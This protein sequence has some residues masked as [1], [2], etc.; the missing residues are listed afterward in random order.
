MDAR[1]LAKALAEP[2]YVKTL[3]PNGWTALIAMARAERL[4]GSLA[5]RLDGL[6]LPA[7]VARILAS[8]RAN[9]DT[10]RTQ[11]LWEAE[12]A[13]RALAPL[14]LEPI[15]LKGTAFAAAGLDAGNGR[16]IGDLDILIAR[17]RLEEA[18]A[19]LLAAGWEWVKPDP[20]DDL[21]YRTHMHE[22]PPMIHASRDRMIDVH[23]TILPLTARPRPDAARLIADS[24]ALG[25]G[26]RILCCEDMIIHAVAHLF[27][28]GD[29][30]GGLRN[31]WDIDRLIRECGDGPDFWGRLIE[32]ARLHQLAKSTSRA[33][34]LTH[35]LFDTP[36]DPHFAWEGR[37]GDVFY[38]GRLLARDRWGRPSRKLLRLAFY[39]RSHWIRMP[40]LMLARHLWAKW[41]K[42]V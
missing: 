27:A 37:K 5:W 9:A 33:L 41:R 19:R 34:R 7:P 24:V 35:H 30:A 17:E 1:H 28:D 38:L 14:G 4:D 15:L 31:L 21:Y 8:A 26:L 18:E 40:P 6:D 2:A 25:N 3:D 13:R 11:A 39:V 20:Y 12:M 42:G 32:R 22:L 16:L 29:L 10:G 23:H 36:V